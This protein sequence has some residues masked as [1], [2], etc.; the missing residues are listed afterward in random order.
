MLLFLFLWFDYKRCHKAA[1]Y[2]GS[3][4]IGA[5]KTSMKIFCNEKIEV[6]MK[7]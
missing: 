5:N 2:I 1:E 6:F 3:G 4:F 7:D